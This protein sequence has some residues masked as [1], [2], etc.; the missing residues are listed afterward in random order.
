MRKA[1]GFLCGVP[2]NRYG[3]PYFSR[4]KTV[5]LIFNTFFLCISKKTLNEVWRNPFL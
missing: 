3:I 2:Y 5:I 1:R 4:F